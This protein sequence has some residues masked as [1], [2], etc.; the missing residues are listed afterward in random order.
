[1]CPRN[2]EGPVWLEQMVHGAEARGRWVCRLEW[3]LLPLF[4]VTWKPLEFWALGRCGLTFTR[5]PLAAVLRIDLGQGQGG[6][7]EAVAGERR[8][9]GQGAGGGGIDEQWEMLAGF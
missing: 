9:L 3:G 2:R 1:M 8:W 5:I 4:W 6:G 7:Q